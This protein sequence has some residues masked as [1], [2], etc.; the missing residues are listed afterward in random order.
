MFMASGGLYF[1]AD[2]LKSGNLD[3]ALQALTAIF[4]MSVNN[5]QNQQAL[6]EA[7]VIEHVLPFLECWERTDIQTKAT[8]CV[9]AASSQNPHNRRTIVNAGAIAALVR[10]LS[11]TPQLQEAASQAIA[12]A[13]KRPTAE[14]QQLLRDWDELTNT[15]GAM[16]DAQE[17]LNRFG[18]V[19]KL[20]QLMEKG[21]SRVKI[22]AT[23]AVANAM[24]ECTENR[25]AFQEANGIAQVVRMLREGDCNAQ[26]CAL[27]EDRVVYLH[28]VHFGVI[29]HFDWWSGVDVEEFDA[30]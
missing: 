24:T 19:E 9:A 14:E 6:F 16:V 2:M 13:V 5:P 10:L 8:N 21:S 26:V 23:A 27:S 29:E 4:E 3:K 25:Q 22:A 15:K 11:S 28:F 17:E 1:M 18:G 7:G 30:M 20:V 12:N